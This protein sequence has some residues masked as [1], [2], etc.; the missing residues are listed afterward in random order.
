MGTYL[1]ALICLR[2]DSPAVIQWQIE[3]AAANARCS[4]PTIFQDVT[5][6]VL[7]KLRV[8]LA[9]V[10]AGSLVTP[11]PVREVDHLFIYNTVKQHISLLARGTHCKHLA[12][13]QQV[14]SCGADC[15]VV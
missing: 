11:E 14:W 9:E 15:L 10:A 5:R 3:D 1:A 2:K 7:I 12:R 8:S 6:W 13:L 4:H